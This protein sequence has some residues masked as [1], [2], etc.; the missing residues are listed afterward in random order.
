M[1]ALFLTGSLVHGGAERHTI[2]LV[3]RLAERGHECHAAYVRDDPSQLARLTGAASVQCLQARKYMDLRAIGRL[4]SLLHQHRFS[5]ILAANQY[6]LLYASLARRR[7]GAD[8]PL[9]ATFHTTVPA[10]AKEWLQ[11]LYY[12]PFFRGADCLVFVCDAQRR[13]WNARRLR[14]RRDEVI[15]NGVDLE[16]WRPRPAAERATLRRVLGLAEAD[17]VV[18][19][20]AVLRPE[21]NHLQLVEAL[22]RL[23]ARG[24]RARA[25]LIGDGPMRA[26]VEARAR[27]LGLAAEVLVTG[28]Q[29][30]VR[31]L[32]GACDAMA[33]CSTAVETFSLAALEAMALARPVVHAEIGGAADMIASGRDGALFPVGDTA[34][35]VERLA[36]L[37]A[38]AAR[39]ALGAAA[40][41]TVEA[42]FSE[43]AMV[44]RYETTFLE[45]DARRSRR[46]D[47][48]RRAA[49]Y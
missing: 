26:A 44:E 15:Y 11:M 17:F 34:A 27:A 14:A 2:T 18:G 33:L 22:A 7:A 10:S 35:L 40:R 16:H 42:R 45:L 47:L 12:R 43:R 24:I 9:L 39:E 28:Y 5:I 4:A 21:K 3:N 46:E 36:A 29:Q 41:A 38:P 25:L 20:C 1:K 37:A 49:A 31:P 8:A 6:A 48:R 30:D 23:R 13:Y 32:I 19:M